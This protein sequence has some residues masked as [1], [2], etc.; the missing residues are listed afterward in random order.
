MRMRKE[1]ARMIKEEI[2]AE[3]SS[4]IYTGTEMEEDISK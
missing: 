1:R 3:E 4:E 2:L